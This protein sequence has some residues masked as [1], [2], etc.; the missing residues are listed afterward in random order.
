[1]T[2]VQEPLYRKCR[3]RCTGSAGAAVPEVQEP[4]YRKCRSRC[5][6]SAGAA[7]PEV[8]GPLYRKCRGRCT[9]SGG[10]EDP[11]LGHHT[12]GISLQEPFR[13]PVSEPGHCLQQ[14]QL[15]TEARKQQVSYAAEYG[16]IT[17]KKLN[18]FK[19]VYFKKSSLKKMYFLFYKIINYYNVR[20][21]FRIPRKIK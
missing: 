16:N 18:N 3:S 7:V 1:V 12:E 13:P 10:L 5:A 8:Q 20:Y 6:G 21:F 14:L 15:L 17:R 19:Y 9:G 2:E 4:L 11:L